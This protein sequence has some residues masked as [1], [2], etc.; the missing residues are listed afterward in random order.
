MILEEELD[1]VPASAPVSIVL[2]QDQDSMGG[3]F[4]AYQS[5][6]GAITQFHVWNRNMTELEQT[7]ILER[8][9]ERNYLPKDPLLSLDRLDDWELH[10]EVSRTD[11][12]FL[13]ETN[14]ASN[15]LI[16]SKEV[17]FNQFYPVCENLG[18]WL[19]AP[20]TDSQFQRML[21]TMVT[22]MAEIKAEKYWKKNYIAFF[23]GFK[24]RE[25]EGRYGYYD[26]NTNAPVEAVPRLVSNTLHPTW[27]CLA[28]YK[29]LSVHS[30]CSGVGS[31]GIC[32]LQP[33]LR[34]SLRG[35]PE[36]HR[37]IFDQEYYIHGIENGQPLSLI[38]I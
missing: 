21:D 4:Q 5:L 28:L 16:L 12:K 23:L 35:L 25:V 7:E 13:C 24:R 20:G 36:A 15:K 14:P 11:E 34:I 33:G 17:V 10:T 31:M 26:L 8:D 27:E 38:H 6:S 18:G 37:T 29:N 9:C 3:M 22:V 19:E 30:T 1:V 32:S 2:G